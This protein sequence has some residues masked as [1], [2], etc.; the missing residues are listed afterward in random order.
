MTDLLAACRLRIA[1]EDR[2]LD[3]AWKHARTMDHVYD[4]A[5]LARASLNVALLR[6]DERAAAPWPVQRDECFAEY[7]AIWTDGS[8]AWRATR[9]AALSDARELATVYE[10]QIQRRVAK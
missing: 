5:I 8:G 10:C 4:L 7:R 9:S 6:H 1:A 2:A 3:L